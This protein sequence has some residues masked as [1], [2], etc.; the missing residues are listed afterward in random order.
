MPEAGLLQMARALDFPA[1]PAVYV[2]CSG[3]FRVERIVRPYHPDPIYLLSDLSTS[4]AGRLSKLIASLA[5]CKEVITFL[6]RHYVRRIAYVQTTAFSKSP[7]SM[8]YRGIFELKTRSPNED[9]FL[10]NYGQLAS[11]KTA[12]ETFATWWAKHGKR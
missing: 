4:R 11:G 12:A 9:G 1:M 7:V 3:I 10:L 5:L 8:K 6:E 2:C